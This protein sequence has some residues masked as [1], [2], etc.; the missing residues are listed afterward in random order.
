M[1]TIEG[2]QLAAKRTKMLLNVNSEKRLST[3]EEFELKRPNERTV[4]V[5][6][7][8]ESSMNNLQQVF[9]VANSPLLPRENRK[10][11]IINELVQDQSEE[12]NKERE[13]DSQHEEPPLI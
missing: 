5:S 3:S 12:E 4:A 10:M 11:D 6:G 2:N 9:K 13:N 8:L 1:K 7:D